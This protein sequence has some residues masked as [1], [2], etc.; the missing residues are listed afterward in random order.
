MFFIFNFKG[1]F[2]PSATRKDLQA[3]TLVGPPRDNPEPDPLAAVHLDNR[4]YIWIFFNLGWRGQVGWAW[5]WPHNFVVGIAQIVPRRISRFLQTWCILK[6]C[7][8]KTSYQGWDS[9]MFI[10]LQTLSLTR[11]FPIKKSSTYKK[12]KILAN[13][14]SGC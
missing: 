2:S 13:L 7:Q 9:P 8:G 5:S 10:T 1:T 4:L 6:V 12:R 14:C 3:F 11:T